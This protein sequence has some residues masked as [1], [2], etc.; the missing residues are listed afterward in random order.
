[1]TSPPGLSGER[2][3]PSGGRRN[4]AGIGDQQL[5]T[6]SFGQT[7]EALFRSPIAASVAGR[8][9]GRGEGLPPGVEKASRRI[10]L[11][12][13]ALSGS[14]VAS[15]AE[16]EGERTKGS[17]WHDTATACRRGGG[18][19]AF[20]CGL[21]LAE[22]RAPVWH[23]RAGARHVWTLKRR[24]S[25]WKDRVAGR[26]QRRLVTTDSSAEQSLVVGCFVR[27]RRARTSAH[28]GG[29]GRSAKGTSGFGP[30]TERGPSGL[31]EAFPRAVTGQKASSRESLTVSGGVGASA[32]ALAR[33]FR[34]EGS[35][36]SAHGT[37]AC[38]MTW[39]SASADR[40]FIVSGSLLRTPVT[41][42]HRQGHPITGTRRAALFGAPGGVARRDPPGGTA[43]STGRD[44]RHSS[45][46]RAAR[47][48]GPRLAELFG[49][50]RDGLT[51]TGN[52]GLFGASGTPPH[53]DR[54]HRALRSTEPPI[55]PGTR[56]LWMNGFQGLESDLFGGH[57]PVSPGCLPARPSGRG[58]P[59][60]GAG[61][62]GCT[63]LTSVGG[64]RHGRTGFGRLQRRAGR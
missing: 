55:S 22:G 20:G 61:T 21:R 37:E 29:C 3:P 12:L 33:R 43:P 60:A 9:S 28:L 6:T 62:R 38:S 13:P 15:A 24:Q 30:G 34:V 49:A 52:Q 26:W 47:N 59:M 4:P 36:A 35:G 42:P 2:L 17:Q 27:F 16:E 32:P 58:R 53:R 56:T 44:S 41:R 45:E 50:P 1:V 8:E 57:A 31:C 19:R 25:P 14:P 10:R 64:G 51:G 11:R 5:T 23:R 39:G 54:E 7:S 18:P 46:C 48:A 40:S 63:P